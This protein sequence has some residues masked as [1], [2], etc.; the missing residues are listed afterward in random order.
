MDFQV[1]Q[2]VFFHLQLLLPYS[3]PMMRK[4]LQVKVALDLFQGEICP[5]AIQLEDLQQVQI[6]P[7]HMVYKD[8]HWA[9][10]FLACAILLFYF[11]TIPVNKKI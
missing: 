4:G 11:G 9:P 6:L 2:M 5:E 7:V 8:V 1:H 10:L 3:F